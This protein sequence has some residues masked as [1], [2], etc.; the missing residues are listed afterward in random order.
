MSPAYQLSDRVGHPLQCIHTCHM[1]L[2]SKYFVDQME[3]HGH[4]SVLQLDVLP[5][6]EDAQKAVMHS[7][8]ASSSYLHGDLSLAT[9]GANR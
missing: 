3:T 7:K 2:F 8:P 9:E 1:V 4:L 5:K 6:E